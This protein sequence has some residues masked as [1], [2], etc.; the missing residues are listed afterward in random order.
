MLLVSILGTLYRIPFDAQQVPPIE[1][2][3]T[4]NSKWVFIGI[5]KEI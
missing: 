1:Q 2:Q 3:V 4:A 5:G